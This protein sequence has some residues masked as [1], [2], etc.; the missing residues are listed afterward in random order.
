[1]PFFYQNR[2]SSWKGLLRGNGLHRLGNRVSLKL[3]GKKVHERQRSHI[4]NTKNQNDTCQTCRSRCLT[5]KKTNKYIGR[6]THV[7]N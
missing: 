5:V 1:M 6:G 2:N 3:K 7:I 4:L